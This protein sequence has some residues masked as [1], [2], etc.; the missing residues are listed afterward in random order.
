LRCSGRLDGQAAI[1]Q[2]FV[3]LNAATS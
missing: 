3:I 2:A 1:P